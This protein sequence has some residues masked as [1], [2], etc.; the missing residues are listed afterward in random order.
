M[1]VKNLSLDLYE[2]GVK[3]ILYNMVV[4][5]LRD[6]LANNFISLQSTNSEDEH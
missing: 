1:Y 5:E 6:L 2:K 4:L 3:Q